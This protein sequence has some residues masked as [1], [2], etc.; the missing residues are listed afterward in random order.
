VS[1]IPPSS[2]TATRA[3]E[4]HDRRWVHAGLGSQDGQVTT[5]DDELIA[6][7]LD[8]AGAA[9]TRTAPNPWV[10]AAVETSDGRVFTGATEAPG[11]AHG[12]IVAMRAATDAGADLHGATLAT[13]LEP[14]A[15]TGRTGPC[16]R[17][18]I[19]AGITRVIAAIE[20]PDP[21]VAGSGI[22]ALEAAGV[23]VTVGPGA[24]DATEQLAAYLHHRR[25]GR[26]YVLL[27]LAAT[28]DGRTAA[29]D[30][31]SQWI[32]GEDARRDVH[33]LRAESQA[34]LV[35]A[36]TV[37]ADDPSLTVRLVDGPDP[38][39]I[40][41]GSVPADAA[42][43]PCTEWRG[44]LVDLLDELGSDGV[45]QL[46]VEGG[47]NTAAQ[48]HAEGL[49][50]RYVVY[51]APAM[52]GGDDARAMFVGEGA[53][54]IGALPRGR[55]VDVLRLGDDLRVELVIDHR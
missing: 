22:A 46:M 18:I 20:D 32:T 13:T 51:L 33:R 10:G 53:A 26:P 11:G 12:E 29:T 35:G 50:D 25:T 34:I 5:P 14:C 39:R 45:L 44:D 21:N 19:D 27:K 55:F 36:G 8:A 49:V 40:V 24:A 6:R 42:V 23:E 15:H 30:G 41:L 4:G 16:T 3:D 7:A 54:T 9:R 2:L 28:T 48:F 31:S 38:R 52:F 17:A 37:R 47:A 1:L 43:H